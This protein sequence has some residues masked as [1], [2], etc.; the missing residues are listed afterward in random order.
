MTQNKKVIGVIGS[1]GSG[2]SEFCKVA[3]ELG[4]FII[5]ADDIAHEV[6]ETAAKTEVLK[7]F[8][9]I[10]R[11]KLG[12]IVF[13]DDFRL[14]KLMKITYKYIEKNIENLINICENNRIVIDAAELHQSKLFALCDQIIAVISEKDSQTSRILIR[15]QLSLTKAANR[16][17]HQKDNDFYV[18]LADVIIENNGTL[19]ELYDSAYLFW[20]N[21]TN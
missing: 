17:E 21:T 18:S 19:K 4:Y 16:L 3:S 1:S 8:G 9:T 12:M 5:D 10:N 15:D 6:L 11:T 20:S 13:N 14:K 2:K 7:E